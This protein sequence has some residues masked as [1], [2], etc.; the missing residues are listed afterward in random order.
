MLENSELAVGQ[1]AQ[2]LFVVDRRLPG[3]SMT[4]YAGSWNQAGH[5]FLARRRNQAGVRNV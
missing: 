5:P 3:V 2:R 4:R 1:A